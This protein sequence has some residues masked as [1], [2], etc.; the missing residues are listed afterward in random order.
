[1]KVQR[2]R[3]QFFVGEAESRNSARSTICKSTRPKFSNT[4]DSNLPANYS[5]E[6]YASPENHPER[7]HH[8][9]G[10][11]RQSMTEIRLDLRVRQS[12][13]MPSGSV[14]DTALSSV[15]KLVTDLSPEFSPP[16]AVLETA[17][18]LLTSTVH[19]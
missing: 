8:S 19:W 15:S 12:G 18:T 1:M 16:G 4:S 13:T 5:V 2:S 11:S 6:K 9:V 14:S 10:L 17:G 7:H 3:P